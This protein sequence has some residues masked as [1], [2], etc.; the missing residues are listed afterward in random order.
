MQ[1]SKILIIYTE[2]RCQN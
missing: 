1:N 2:R